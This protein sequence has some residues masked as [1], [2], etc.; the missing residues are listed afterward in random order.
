MEES[1][2]VLFEWFLL[3]DDLDHYE[4]LRIPREATYDDVKRAFHEF[5]NT[6][7]PDAQTSRSAEERLALDA[8]FKRGTEAYAVLTDAVQR[9]RYDEQLVATYSGSVAPSHRVPSA[10]PV[11]PQ[12]SRLSDH[13][14][15]ASALPHARRAEELLEEGKLA[16]ARE[17]LATASRIEPENDL[18][19]AYLRHI[20]AELRKG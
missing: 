4:L 8:I 7:H 9:A 5:A 17:Q 12:K 15:S 19:R 18:L 1:S 16:A 2:E 20:E 6:F 14:H 11:G 3:L 13:V 10:A